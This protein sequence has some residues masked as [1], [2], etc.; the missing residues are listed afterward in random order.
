MIRSTSY[1]IRSP[2]SVDTCRVDG[3]IFV[4]LLEGRYSMAGYNFHAATGAA[5]PH[6]GCR[7]PTGAQLAARRASGEFEA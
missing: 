2:K 3:S 5:L 7:Y 6:L 1:L 4:T